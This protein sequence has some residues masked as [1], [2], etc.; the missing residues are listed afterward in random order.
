MRTNK[1]NI[2]ADIPKI[3]EAAQVND[4]A[5]AI[6][7]LLA[8]FGRSS[9]SSDLNRIK[10]NLRNHLKVDT[11][12][13]ELL[14][15]FNRWQH[16]GLGKLELSRNLASSHHKFHWKHNYRDIGRI[17]SEAGSQK[18]TSRPV[19]RAAALTPS[20]GPQAAVLPLLPPSVALPT[21]TLQY[22]I[23]GQLYTLQVPH[24]LTKGE[25]QELGQFVT[26]LGK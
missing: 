15:V 24:D 23:R 7:R 26:R 9:P 20:T 6:M 18:P 16:L 3:I 14:W 19:D 4:V 21:L 25:A 5:R 22:P 13:E 17:G 2:E 12:W 10:A 8:K 11:N 1:T